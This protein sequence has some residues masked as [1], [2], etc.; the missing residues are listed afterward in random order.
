VG[1]GRRSDCEPYRDLIE[2]KLEQGLSAQRIY[3]DLVGEHG[4][5]ASYWSVR[6]YA[7]GLAGKSE[8]PMRRME[9]A[10]GEEAQV[11]FGRGAPVVDADSKRRKTNVFRIVLSHSRKGYSEATYTQT[12]ED[13]L[14]ALENA[15]AHFG[16]VP[17]TLV[18]DNLKAAVVHPDWFDPELTPKV[19]SFCRHYGTVILP[20][21]PYTPR[22]KGK[23][24]AGVKYVKNNGL[25]GH[26]FPTL[27]AENRH[28]ADWERTVADTR[29][30]GTTKR[31]VG[32]LYADAERAAL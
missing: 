16:G 27:E 18:I 17:K 2:G 10:A 26:T 25:A 8:R 24:E 6:R 12:T 9:V 21:K 20:T 11:D 31:Q 7:Q 19:Q 30:H 4:F 29:I 5:T 14:R 15:F 28:L 23:V 13:F 3:Q 32:Q 1:S 22:H